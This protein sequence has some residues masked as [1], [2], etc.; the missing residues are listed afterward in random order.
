MTACCPN[1]HPLSLLSTSRY[2]SFLLFSSCS[3]YLAS[4]LPCRSSSLSFSLCSPLISY[5]LAI[6]FSVILPSS[7]LIPFSCFPSHLRASTPHLPFTSTPTS[8]QQKPRVQ[9]WEKESKSGSC[10]CCR[11]E[12]EL[13]S[14]EGSEGLCVCVRLCGS[15]PSQFEQSSLIKGKRRDV[16]VYSWASYPWEIH[17][18]SLAFTWGLENKRKGASVSCSSTW[19]ARQSHR[20]AQGRADSFGLLAEIKLTIN[21]DSY[22]REWHTEINR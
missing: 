5:K 17:L 16:H 14:A 4:L 9:N 1:T 8:E 6:P 12:A 15:V 22:I 3:P 13:S 19:W 20:H 18:L 2:F 21:E 10:C 7:V 11:A